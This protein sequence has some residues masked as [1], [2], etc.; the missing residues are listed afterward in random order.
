[1]FIFRNKLLQNVSGRKLIN[2]GFCKGYLPY[3]VSSQFC[4]L[5]FNIMIVFL[6]Q[7]KQDFTERFL[8]YIWFKLLKQKS[9]DT[10]VLSY[11]LFSLKIIENSRTYQRKK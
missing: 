8:D 7:Y 4:V 11:L 5:K 3:T 1:M 9:F 6:I 2:T 10:L